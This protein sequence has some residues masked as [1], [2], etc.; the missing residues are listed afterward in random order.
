MTKQSVVVPAE[1]TVATP[2][3]TAALFPYPPPRAM[4]GVAV[5]KKYLQAQMELGS[6]LINGWVDSMRAS[7]PTHARAA[8]V[9]AAGV[10]DEHTAWM[11]SAVRSTQ[12]I[13]CSL[14]DDIYS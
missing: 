9:L 2:P 10:D 14:R 8:A 5:R 13:V 12:S 6:G 1:M 3:N 4:P 11:V 7:S